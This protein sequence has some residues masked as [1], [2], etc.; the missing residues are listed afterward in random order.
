MFE[1]EVADFHRQHWYSGTSHGLALAVL[2]FKAE[3]ADFHRQHWYSGTSQRL[4]LAGLEALYFEL[5]VSLHHLQ[6]VARNVF[7]AVEMEGFVVAHGDE[8]TMF[9]N[10]VERHFCNIRAI[11]FLC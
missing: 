2:V 8:H 5:V 10:I 1:A 7:P 3:V 6:L 9:E 11:T 4:A